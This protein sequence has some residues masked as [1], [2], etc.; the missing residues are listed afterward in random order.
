MFTNNNAISIITI[1]FNNLVELLCTMNSVDALDAKPFEHLLIDGSSNSDIKNYLENNPQPTYRKW[2]CERDD[3]IADAF[4]KGI[5]HATGSIIVMLNSG[6]EFIDKNIIT[7]VETTFNTHQNI[8]WLHS[9][10][11]LLRGDKWVT[12]GKPF[13]P[14]KLYRG[15]RSLCHQTMFIK[16]ELHD[17]YGLYNPAEK[18]GMDYDFV[19]SIAAEPFVFLEASLVKFAPDGI[20]LTQYLQSLRDAKRI[21]EKHFGNSILL[22]I[23]QIRLKVLHYLLQ[24]PIGNFLYSIK[25]KLKLENM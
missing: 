8:T 3:G 2:I 19:C 7:R 13:D 10:Y 14:K 25:A 9:K 21:Y 5:R 6:D 18:I 1:C 23:W 17:K 16:K 15:M 11:T 22:D 20:S 24:S 12:I 4:N